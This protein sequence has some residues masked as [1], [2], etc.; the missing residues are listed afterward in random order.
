MIHVDAVP[1][2]SVSN[3]LAQIAAIVAAGGIARLDVAV[4]YA[5]IGGVRALLDT[6]EAGLGP[7]WPTVEK[8]WITAFD[9]FRSEPLAIRTLHELPN[10]AVKIHDGTGILLRAKCTPR[11]PFHPK[12]FIFSGPGRHAAFAGSGNL[13]RSGMSLGHELGL[14]LDYREP[15]KPADASLKAKVGSIQAWFDQLWLDATPVTTVISRYEE[16]Y[17]AQTNLANPTPTDDDVVSH[18]YSRNALGPDDLRKLRACKHLWIE[19]GKITKNR[20]HKLPGNQLMMKRMSRVFFGHQAIDLPKDTH[21]GDLRILFAGVPKSD[22]SLTFSNN[23]MDKLT[24]PVPGPGGPS[25]YDNETLLFTRRGLHTFDLELGT[26]A[27]VKAWRQ[28]SRAIDA[29]F[30]MPGGRE[31]GVF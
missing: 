17:D 12:A 11:T 4:A 28:K 30:T 16:L 1:Q 29:R 27:Q 5:T 8:R 31:W 18:K 3:N 20:G 26:K 19:G 22:C 10:S 13:S 23:L 21:I 25:A 15:L 7:A 9:Y 6:L 2:P 14:L 24:L